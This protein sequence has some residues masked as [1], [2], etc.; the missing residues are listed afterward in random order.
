MRKII[1]IL[2]I[3]AQVMTL[4]AK[5]YYVSPQGKD[6]NSGESKTKA[7]ASLA[8]AQA[9]I[10]PGDT[11]FIMPGTYKV[12][13]KDLMAPTYQKVYAVA[14]LLDKSGTPQKPISYI[15]VMDAQGNRPVFDFSEVKPD[16]RI[17]GFLLR[18]SYLRIKN[19]ESIGIQVTQAHHTQSENFRVFNAS[20]N[21]LE[22]TTVQ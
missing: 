6:K 11:V 14:F 3:L 21:I 7:F 22:N 12:K 10:A 15:G 2:S 1:C 5:N 17:T 16:A 18:G 19:I 8:K 4:S 20:H 9:L 13:Q